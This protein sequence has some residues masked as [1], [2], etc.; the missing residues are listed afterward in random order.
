M[1]KTVKTF[2]AA[3]ALCAVAAIARPAHAAT[4]QYVV[5][6]NFA[7]TATQPGGAYANLDFS[8]WDNC[9][10]SGTLGTKCASGAGLLKAVCPVGAVGA[11]ALGFDTA[12]APILNTVGLGILT[13][14]VYSSNGTTSLGQGGP[15]LIYP[16]GGLRFKTNLYGINS[17]GALTTQ[18]L[19]LTDAELAPAQ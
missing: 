12:V 18:F 5:P 4:K 16:N 14:Q 6:P 8:G 13:T 2:L 15:C 10:V 9:I 11:Y 3:L 19:F 17:N 1:T 7:A